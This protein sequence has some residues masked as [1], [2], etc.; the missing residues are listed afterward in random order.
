MLRIGLNID[1]R[2][3]NLRDLLL[4]KPGNLPTTERPLA[5]MQRGELHFSSRDQGWEILIPSVACKNANSPFFGAK[6]IRLILLDLC[7]LYEMLGARIERHGSRLIGAATDPET[8]F[9]KT[10]KR[11]S[12][13]AAYCQNTV[14]E[15]WR[16]AIPRCGIYN[17]WT[18]RGAI[19][20]LLPH[21]PQSVRD[22]LAS[23]ILKQ[24]GTYEQASYTIQDTAEMVAQH[25]GR[26]LPQD[27]VAIAARILN[28]VWQAT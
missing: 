23:H 22:V 16:A 21:A 17:R 27:K 11:A 28:P 18:N 19:K 6:R 5:D 2:Q 26:F 4:Y 8:L 24:T 12:T 15:A 13:N 3:K 14:Y 10:A 1:L 20:G 7:H 9:V 25:Y